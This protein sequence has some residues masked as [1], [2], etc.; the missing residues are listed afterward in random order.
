MNKKEYLNWCERTG[1]ITIN[2]WGYQEIRGDAYFF[3]INPKTDKFTLVRF[4]IKDCDYQLLVKG[5]TDYNGWAEQ[6]HKETCNY[7]NNQ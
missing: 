5:W 2:D 4:R 7:W 3:I 1:H 6:F